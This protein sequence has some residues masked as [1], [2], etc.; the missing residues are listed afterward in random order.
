MEAPDKPQ[1]SWNYANISSIMEWIFRLF[2]ILKLLP[3]ILAIFV[4]LCEFS[5]FGKSNNEILAQNI[6]LS[7]R[8]SYFGGISAYSYHFSGIFPEFRYNA[9]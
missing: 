7:L 5:I 3:I 8:I 4:E 1:K 2:K 6:G 9:Q